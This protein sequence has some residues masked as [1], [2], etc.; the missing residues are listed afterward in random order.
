MI[1]RL[2]Y[3]QLKRGAQILLSVV[4]DI[5]S[6]PMAASAELFTRYK[7]AAKTLN[8]KIS[9]VSSGGVPAYGLSLPGKKVLNGLGPAQEGMH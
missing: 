7:Q 5:P 2:A 4:V 3:C 9:S 6:T 1:K 8:T